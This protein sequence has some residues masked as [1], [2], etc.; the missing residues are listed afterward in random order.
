MKM[1]FFQGPQNVFFLPFIWIISIK[2]KLIWD[3]NN[4]IYCRFC[5]FQGMYDVPLCII[6]RFLMSGI[7]L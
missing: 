2:R 3:I 6:L 5:C 7:A 4:M 1:S